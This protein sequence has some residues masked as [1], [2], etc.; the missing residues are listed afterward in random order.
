MYL[1]SHDRKGAVS[2]RGRATPEHGYVIWNARQRAR[3]YLAA[4]TVISIR[5]V[6][7]SF[8]MP[9]VVRAGRGSLK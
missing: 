9:T 8:A 1:Q 5:A 2:H 6:P 4:V 7:T 3:R